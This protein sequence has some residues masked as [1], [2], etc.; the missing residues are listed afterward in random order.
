[1]ICAEVKITWI[2]NV[3][4]WKYVPLKLLTKYSWKNII[5]FSFCVKTCLCMF[6]YVC[7]YV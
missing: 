3:W 4:M 5:K 1:M 2:F 7:I 6:S